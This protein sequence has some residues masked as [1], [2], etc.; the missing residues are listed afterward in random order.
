MNDWKEISQAFLLL[1][2]QIDNLLYIMYNLCSI[3]YLLVWPP[4]WR[5]R[6][7]DPPPPFHL[8]PPYPSAMDGC[9][10]KSRMFVCHKIQVN[11]FA[12]MLPIIC[13]IL[14]YV[15]NIKIFQHFFSLNLR[16]CQKYLNYTK[17]FLDTNTESV[18]Q[19]LAFIAT[20][21]AEAE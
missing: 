11:F 18:A 6:G 21:F 12:K 3:F 4:A 16:C 13:E 10:V 19:I 15:C 7:G 14:Y 20:I 2:L 17:I 5:G 9:R 1:Y 8:P